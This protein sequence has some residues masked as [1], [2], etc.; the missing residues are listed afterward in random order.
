M[1]RRASYSP[2]GCKESDTT[3]H[4]STAAQ[5][6]GL[7]VKNPPASARDT[8]DTSLKEVGEILWKKERQPTLVLLPG[9]SQGQRSLK[10]D[11]P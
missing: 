2:W 7:V 1:D 5:C 8:G 10:G 3:E 6:G 9:E 4:L 11:S